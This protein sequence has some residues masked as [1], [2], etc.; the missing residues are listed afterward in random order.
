[1]DDGHRLKFE[2][3][4]QEEN[5]HPSTGTMKRRRDA[6]PRFQI[7]AADFRVASFL[8]RRR[9]GVS[10]TPEAP[11]C[12]TATMATTVMLARRSLPPRRRS[13]PTRCGRQSPDPE[14]H[15]VSASAQNGV[16]V[17][18]QRQRCRWKRCRW[19]GGQ[20]TPGPGH[21]A[22]WSVG[23]HVRQ[24]LARRVAAPQHQGLP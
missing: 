1:M 17:S 12:A 6:G 9:S 14:R 21:S 4:G 8:G 11:I 3:A 16:I 7:D 10:G 23:R 19:H 5:V 2:L 18:G 15:Q 13:T 22:S 20:G 24:L